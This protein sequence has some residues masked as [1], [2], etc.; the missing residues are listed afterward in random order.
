MIAALSIGDSRDPREL[1]LPIYL[2]WEEDVKLLSEEAPE[3]LKNVY[4]TA[5]MW[6]AWM[7]SEKAFFSNAINGMIMAM[8]FAMIVIYIATKNWIITLFAIHCV[9]FVCGSEMSLQVLRGYEMGVAESIGTI[10]VIGFSVDYVVHLAAH[11][12]HSSTPTRFTRTAESVGEMGIS[13]FSG[14]MTTIGSACFLYGGQMIFFQKFAFIITSTCAIALL[15]SM[16]YFIALTH[17][18]GP[19]GGTGQLNVKKFCKN[20]KT[21]EKKKKSRRNS[22]VIEIDANEVLSAP[23]QNE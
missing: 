18:F 10:L 12:V 23:R 16:V 20:K 22:K 14:A 11:Y 8:G 2:R 3:G 1:K 19:E 5:S 21:T 9:G 4:Q 13:I 15:Y 7:E 6:W 17:A